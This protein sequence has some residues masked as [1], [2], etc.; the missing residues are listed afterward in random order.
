MRTL[1]EEVEILCSQAVESTVTYR[2]FI[3]CVKRAFILEALTR[4]GGNFSQAACDLGMHRN[5]LHRT[6][7]QLSMPKGSWRHKQ[8]Q[9]RKGAHETSA[10]A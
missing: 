1:Q 6:M 2:D 4:A 7:R 8:Q 9:Q 3:C 5:T 10:V